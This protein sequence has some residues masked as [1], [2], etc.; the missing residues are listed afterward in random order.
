MTCERIRPELVAFHF[1]TVQS[2][3]RGELEAHLASCPECLREFFA[4]KAE[5]ETAASVPRPSVA[6]RARLRRSILREITGEQPVRA[7]AWWERPLAFGFASAAVA[8]AVFAV[9]FLATGA[10]VLPHAARDASPSHQI[11]P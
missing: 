2:E 7:W 10:G 5:V 8:S 9:Q 11:S 4:I 3:A 1:G 6:A